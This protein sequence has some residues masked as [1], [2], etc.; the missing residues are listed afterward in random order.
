MGETAISGK[1]RYD[2]DA[3]KQIRVKDLHARLLQIDNDIARQF[4]SDLWHRMISGGTIPTAVIGGNANDIILRKLFG[5]HSGSGL[6]LL[7]RLRGVRMAELLLA[8]RT[9]LLEA[10]GSMHWSWSL[11]SGVPRGL[12]RGTRLDFLIHYLECL[13]D[14]GWRLPWQWMNVSI[15]VLAIMLM[16]GLS[17]AV[18]SLAMSIPGSGLVF[19]ILI[20]QLFVNLPGALLNRYGRIRL[21]VLY[22]SFT[23][24][25]VEA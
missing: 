9:L 12:E 3:L 14:R 15:R 10:L 4:A 16:L 8:D 6:R 20:A 1:R 7:E 22:I 24:E 13:P 23:D 25:F 18:L 21:L 19:G 2:Q 17:S 11:L 5:M